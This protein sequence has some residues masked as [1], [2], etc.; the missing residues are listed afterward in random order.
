[1]TRLPWKWDYWLYSCVSDW[2]CPKKED[3]MILHCVK[4]G[5]EEGMKIFSD[6]NGERSIFMVN[7]VTV[8]LY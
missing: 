8:I 1:M 2:D 3:T 5:W 6:M 7:Y 4:P